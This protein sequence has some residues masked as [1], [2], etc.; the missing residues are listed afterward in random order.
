MPLSSNDEEWFGPAMKSIC[1]ESLLKDKDGWCV[2]YLCILLA[3]LKILGTM[4]IRTSCL[5]R[6]HMCLFV[7]QFTPIAGCLCLC[8]PEGGV[9]EEKYMVVETHS[10]GRL[11]QLEEVEISRA[12]FEIYEGGV[13]SSVELHPPLIIDRL[14]VFTSRPGVCCQY[15]SR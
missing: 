6:P 11:T 7:R 1:E 3:M 14:E 5:T 8:T 4:L 2:S 12:M 15:L 9:E 13:V 10:D